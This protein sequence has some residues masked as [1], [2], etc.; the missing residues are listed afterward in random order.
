MSI[1]R[2]TRLTLAGL[3]TDKDCVLERLQTLG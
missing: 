3:A 2:L 1:Q